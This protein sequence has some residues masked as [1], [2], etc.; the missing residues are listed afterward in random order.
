MVKIFIIRNCTVSINKTGPSG[1]F[2]GYV[3]ESSGIWRIYH[4]FLADVWRPAMATLGMASTKCPTKRGKKCRVG[5]L[6]FHQKKTLPTSHSPVA[7]QASGVHHVNEFSPSA[8]NQAA[9]QNKF[10]IIGTSCSHETVHPFYFSGANAGEEAG[11]EEAT[12]HG[13]EAETRRCLKPRKHIS[14]SPF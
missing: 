3:I 12:N 10:P 9:F 6:C 13:W 1:K 11:E 2:S 4:C 7:A 8:R 14:Q 5:N